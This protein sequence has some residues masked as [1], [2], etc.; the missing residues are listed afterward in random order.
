MREDSIR[1]Q[2]KRKQMDR[3]RKIR[4][5]DLEWNGSKDKRNGKS[6]CVL[7]SRVKG[8]RKRNED[9]RNGMEWSGE[10]Q[11]RNKKERITFCGIE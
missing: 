6:K 4:E 8:N 5:L 11:G 3:V 1:K 2:G 10:M 7:E 9:E